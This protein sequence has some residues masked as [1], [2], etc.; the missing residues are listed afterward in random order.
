MRHDYC[1]GA[2]SHSLRAFKHFCLKK[3]CI[4][5]RNSM[6]TYFLFKGLDSLLGKGFKEGL[7]LL[8]I[9]TLSAIDDSAT[10][11]IRRTNRCVEPVS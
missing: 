3:A 5:F 1:L 9:V 6:Q 7:G 8:R 11:V 2:E 4:K 10:G